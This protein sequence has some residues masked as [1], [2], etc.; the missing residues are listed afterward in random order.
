MKINCKFACGVELDIE[1]DKNGFEICS[2]DGRVLFKI[3]IQNNKT[4]PDLVFNNNEKDYFIGIVP[5]EAD[6]TYDN[7]MEVK[8]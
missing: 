3:S 4:H 7:L 6:M 1:K 8:G 2:P 5:V